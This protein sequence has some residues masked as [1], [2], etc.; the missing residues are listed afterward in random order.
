MLAVTA[1]PRRRARAATC[2][3]A[4]AQRYSF[5]PPKTFALDLRLARLSMGIV[6]QDLCRDRGFSRV[7]R[8]MAATT[9][10]T[11]TMEETRQLT[12]TRG[13]VLDAARTRRV[14]DPR[15]RS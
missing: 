1:A 11:R 7:M 9:R 15:P 10:E 4:L 12:A 6:E 5:V 3:G 13:S 14:D 8:S 2:G